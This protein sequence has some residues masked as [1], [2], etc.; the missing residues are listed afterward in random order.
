MLIKQHAIISFFV[1]IAIFYNDLN[2]AII[3]F[4]SAVLIDADHVLSYWY[5]TRKFSVRSY[6]IIKHWCLT[7]GTEMN[8]YLPCHNIWFFGLLIW[9]ALK[10]NFLMPILF[11][12]CLHYFLD[13]IWDLHLFF[14]GKVKRP[15][16]RWLF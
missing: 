7:R 10:I 15:Y 14:A 12:V 8:I 2:S 4:L 1:S 11:G 5:Y 13:I 16:R 9:S 6:R 3:F